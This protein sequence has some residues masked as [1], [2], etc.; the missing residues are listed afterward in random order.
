MAL[1]GAGTCVVGLFPEN[2]DLAVHSV[3]AG[4]FVAGN[5]ALI[6]LSCTVREQA[7]RS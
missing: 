5:I 4:P 2:V 7:R 6:I 3:G 1:A